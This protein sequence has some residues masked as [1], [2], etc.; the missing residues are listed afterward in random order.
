MKLF[1]L[2]VA[3]LIVA[4]LVGL[5]VVASRLPEEPL[6]PAEVRGYALP[7]DRAPVVCDRGNPFTPPGPDEGVSG[8]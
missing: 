2:A 7:S 5:D 4:S 3:A 1:A 6:T 8:S